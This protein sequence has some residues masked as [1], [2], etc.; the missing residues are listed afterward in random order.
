MPKVSRERVPP[1][2][3]T[4]EMKAWVEREVASAPPVSQEQA[5]KL[6]RIFQGARDHQRQ[7]REMGLCRWNECRQPMTGWALEQ[8]DGI[9]PVCQDCVTAHDLTPVKAPD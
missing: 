5:E 4:P 9:V 3:P 7:L 1:P 2:P 6:Q 8:V